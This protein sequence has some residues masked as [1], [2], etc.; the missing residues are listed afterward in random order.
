MALPS[1]LRA[2]LLALDAHAREA[3]AL[4]DLAA[5]QLGELDRSAAPMTKAT[6]PLLTAA[7]NVV[8]AKRRIGDV[9]EHLDASREVGGA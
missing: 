9:L 5:W 6:E 3:A 7:T 4:L 1:Q 2:D 8:L